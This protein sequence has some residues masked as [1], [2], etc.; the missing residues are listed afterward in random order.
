MSLDQTRPTRAATIMGLAARLL[1]AMVVLLALA[2]PGGKASAAAPTPAA[3]NPAPRDLAWAAS[4]DEDG[5]CE[6]VEPQELLECG[7]QIEATLDEPLVISLLRMLEVRLTADACTELLADVWSQQICIVGSRECGKLNAG[8]PPPL[9][10]EWVSSSSS[11]H[12]SCA[13]LGLSA[14]AVRRLGFAEHTHPFVSRDLA[15][16]VPPPRLSGH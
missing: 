8:A 1:G 15:P 10:H 16:P 14:E 3:S 12:S 11:G 4:H 6:E 5:A 9:P 2:L 13:D 7:S